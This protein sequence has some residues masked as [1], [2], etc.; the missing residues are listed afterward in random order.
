MLGKGLNFE[1]KKLFDLDIFYVEQHQKNQHNGFQDNVFF[2]SFKNV[3]K[4]KNL[5]K[6]IFN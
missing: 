5:S 3:K 4:L 2:L 1:E 6:N